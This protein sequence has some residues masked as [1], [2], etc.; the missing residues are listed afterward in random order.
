V[1]GGGGSFGIVTAI[2]FALHP[3]PRSTQATS[4]GPGSARPRVLHAWGRADVLG[5]RRAHFARA[6]PPVP[7]AAPPPRA[8]P[9]P[10]VRRRR[11]RVH[12]RRGG[13]RRAARAAARARAG[14]GHRRDDSADD[15]PRAAQRPAAADPRTR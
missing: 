11:V 1:R 5:A 3:L 6:D 10:A 4:T 7:A 15:A 9:R 14:D 2:E 13:R 12:R 8:P